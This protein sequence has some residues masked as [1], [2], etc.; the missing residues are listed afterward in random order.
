M[1]VSREILG[2]FCASVSAPNVFNI[3]NHFAMT[4]GAPENDLASQSPDLSLKI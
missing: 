3:K 2:G 1:I 4:T